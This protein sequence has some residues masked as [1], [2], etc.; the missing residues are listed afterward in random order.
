MDSQ[1]N[2]NAGRRMKASRPNGN[3]SAL[4]VRTVAACF[5]CFCS[6]LLSSPVTARSQ[7]ARNGQWTFE[8]Y[9]LYRTTTNVTITQVQGYNW[10][11]LAGQP[12][13]P[14]SA[15]GGDEDARLNFPLGVG[16]GGAG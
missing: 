2:R 6:L 10:I 5:L 16:A 8:R 13:G 12:G 9:G 1:V 15:A 11:T 4:C 7:T 14:G 3:R